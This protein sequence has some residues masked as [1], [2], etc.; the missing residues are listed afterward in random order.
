MANFQILQDVVKDTTTAP[1]MSLTLGIVQQAFF[2]IREI[3]S[4]I[5]P[6]TSQAAAVMSMNLY[7]I[8]NTNYERILI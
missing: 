5:G 8:A 1:T 2:S 7:Q 3:A 4:A 6:T